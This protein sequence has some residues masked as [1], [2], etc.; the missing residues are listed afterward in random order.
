[1]RLHLLPE[2]SRI[3]AGLVLPS[4]AKPAVARAGPFVSITATV[5]IPAR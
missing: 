2:V 1:M 3:W 5:N 4:V